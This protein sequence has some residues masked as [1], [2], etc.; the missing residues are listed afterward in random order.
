M[1]NQVHGAIQP[2]FADLDKIIAGAISPATALKLGKPDLEACLYKPVLS[3]C[4]TIEY[5]VSSYFSLYS[6]SAAA[7]M[8][9]L[10]MITLFL[11][12]VGSF[13]LGF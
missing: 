9:L 12:L 2:D 13:F 4:L 11:D 8:S 5:L 10:S 6:G 3:R 1:F 7:K